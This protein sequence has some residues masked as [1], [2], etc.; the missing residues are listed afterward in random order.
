MG[1]KKSKQK[2]NV[3]VLAGGPSEDEHEVSLATSKQVL[4]NLDSS[5][6]TP[7][8]VVISKDGNWSIPREELKEKADIVFVALHGL[9]GEDGTVQ[10]EL[11]EMNISYTGSA[12]QPSALAMDKNAS[13]A[14][15]RDNGF[16]VPET[17][18]ATRED[19]EDKKRE[20]F[21]ED[22]LGDLSFPVVIKPNKSGSSAG[23]FIVENKNDAL[24]AFRNIFAT[25]PDCI[26]QPYIR[27]RE[28]TC[29]VLD[30]G[31]NSSALAL[32]PTEIIP[33]LGDFFDYDSK[34]K[35][36]GAKEITPAQLDK[37]TLASLRNLSKK[38]H[39]VLGCSGMSRADFILSEDGISYILEVN[40][41]PGMTE[42]SLLPQGAVAM[43]ISFSDMLERI[44]KA[45][46][47]RCQK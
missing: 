45:G 6:F 18:Y 35:K 42:T 21:L 1:R 8:H 5:K 37:E 46:I 12:P 7:V 13:L 43:G 11:E 40:T 24:E 29:G 19:W 27:G 32:I 2:L 23:I 25:Y 14:V 34:Y 36:G 47:Y 31:D 15:L 41:I 3:A 22:A 39:K 9:Y 4:A 38:A 44:I 26:T 30:D 10:Q 33:S 28:M 17:I 16:D 20:S